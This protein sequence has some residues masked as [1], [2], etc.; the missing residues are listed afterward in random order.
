MCLADVL[1]YKYCFEPR[2]QPLEIGAMKG[3]V[4]LFVGALL[5]LS[6]YARASLPG[7]LC[8]FL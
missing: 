2:T 8:K 6:G 5:L 3:S 4:V 1:Q 7:E